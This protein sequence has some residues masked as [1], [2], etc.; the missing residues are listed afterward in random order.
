MAVSAEAKQKVI[1]YR[2]CKNE[3]FYFGENYVKIAQSGIE[4]TPKL[5]TPQK[6]FL[7]SLID[8]HY[9]VL[10]K[11]RQ[12]GGST[13]AQMYCAWAMIFNINIVVGIVS[14]KGSEATDFA[15]KVMQIIQ[16]VPEWMRP[17]F[18]KQSEQS[19]RLANG[20]ELFAEAVIASNP[21]GI[22]V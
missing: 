2:K 18:T 12:T 22:F 5:Y 17:K 15:K 14:R 21:G 9:C 19:F 16:N 4:V 8:D 20:S 10:L 11:T 1:E 3:L 7:Q 13:A 6:T